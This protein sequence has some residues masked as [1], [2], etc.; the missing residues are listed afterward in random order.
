MPPYPTPIW[1]RRTDAGDV[2][3]CGWDDDGQL[4]LGS[5]AALNTALPNALDLP[6]P[7]T[8][9]PS[10]DVTATAVA[11]GAVHSVVLTGTAAPPTAF[12][13]VADG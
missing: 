1:S 3:G 12:R 9:A 11:A 2:Y 10:A 6:D 13:P 5:D 4:G 7:Q 8:G